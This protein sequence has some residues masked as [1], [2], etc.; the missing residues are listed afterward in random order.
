MMLIDDRKKLI[1]KAIIDS[2]IDTAEPVGSRT[3]ARKHGIG[4]SS[5]TIRNEMSDLEERGFLEQP[6]TSSGRIP[7]DKGY[8]FYVDQLM[9]KKELTPR[10]IQ[11]IK[12]ALKMRIGELGQLISQVSAVVSDIT[13]YTSMAM[14]PQMNKSVLKSVQV[15]P[16]DFDK[17]LVIVITNAG[18][19]KNSLVRAPVIPSPDSLQ[20]L[21]SMLSLNLGGVML[22]NINIDDLI[23]KMK[24]ETNL[25]NE[26]AICIAN[27]ISDC[28]CQVFASD[29]YLEGTS[30]IFN[31]PEFRS[32]PKAKQFFDIL[33]TK[34]ILCAMMRMSVENGGIK[35]RIG[36]EN[37]IKEIKD[38]SVVTTTY[39]LNDQIMG[40]IGVIG[41]TRM[42][43]AKVIASLNYIRKAISK[44][45]MQI[46]EL[47]PG[48]PR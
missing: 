1:L 18:V 14:T 48:G 35:V 38:Y 47:G 42:E 33:N 34:K 13:K 12:E 29:V 43:Y 26:T 9:S 31:F 30:N 15:L 28:L 24:T 3:I 10:E 6:H 2:Y 19:V 17:M 4:L 16:V 27:G 7:S 20:K 39:V 45:L 21:S 40:S 41:P 11:Q 46:M 37:E 5:A 22:D 25:D 8:R 36:T 23:Q 32:V 44:E